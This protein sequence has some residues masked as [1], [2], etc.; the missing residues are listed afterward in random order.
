MSSA[1][2]PQTDGAT[3][4]ANRT[5]MQMLRQ[6]VKPDQKDWVRKLP[7]I[8][9]AINIA[10]SEST[11]YSPF[12]LN[13]GRMPRSLLWDKPDAEEYPRVSAFAQKMKNAMMSAHDNLLEARAKQTR[14]ANRHRRPAPFKENDLVYISSQNISF[15]KGRARKLLP[16]YIGPYRIV[17][18]FGNKS[19]RVMLPSHLKQQGLHDVFHSSLLRIHI[20]NDD[21]LFPG[22]LDAQIEY[23]GGKDGEW[24]IEKIKAHSGSA[25]HSVFE[26][27]W[28][29]GDITWL[30]YEQISQSRAMVDYLESQGVS[31][32]RE[33]GGGRGNPPEGVPET[34]L[35]CLTPAD[36]RIAPSYKGQ[37]RGGSGTATTMQEF[38]RH[39]KRMGNSGYTLADPTPVKTT[40][41]LRT[42]SSTS[43]DIT[44]YFVHTNTLIPPS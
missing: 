17:K 35:A 33:L 12:F 21:R 11:G 22:R 30:P 9:F 20:P 40:S 34:A 29:S 31:S 10:H 6:C 23:L 26:V 25:A 39:F 38:N 19:F 13:S 41:S 15:P 36:I 16:K 32:I 3:E 27:L 43:Y 37:R 2:H 1:Y 7:A 24:M 5:I 8:E 42:K 4:R 44:A 14:S 18:D 28:K